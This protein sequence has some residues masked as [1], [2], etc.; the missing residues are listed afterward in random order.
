MSAPGPEGGDALDLDQRELC[1]DGS[2][3]GVLGEG[4]R[5]RECGRT[6][7]EV[8]AGEPPAEATAVR[9]GTDE[10]ASSAGEGAAPDGDGDPGDDRRLC[11]DGSCVGLIGSDGRCKVCGL[12]EDAPVP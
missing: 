9:P 5:C 11:P 2:C 3:T 6:A 4:G 7:A 10:D 8:E 12:A 1:A